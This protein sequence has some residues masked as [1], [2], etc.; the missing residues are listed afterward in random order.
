MTSIERTTTILNQLGGSKF[1]A[2]TGSKNFVALEN[3][4][5]MTLTRNISGAN[6]LEIVLNGLDLYDV[7]FYKYTPHR[8][9]KKTFV[10][11]D[12]KVKEIANFYDIYCDQLQSI[13][14]SV[15]GMVTHL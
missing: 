13:F 6:R 3:G 7:K 2:M 8:L 5:R 4:V 12:E 14:T 15:T 1:T 10:F 11:T 9:N